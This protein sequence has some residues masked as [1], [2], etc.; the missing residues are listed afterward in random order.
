MITPKCRDG[1][2]AM[3][4]MPP[5]AWVPESKFNQLP[6]Y[7]TTIP[8]GKTIGKQWKAQNSK[9]MWFLCEYKSDPDPR[10]IN[11]KKLR[12]IIVKGQ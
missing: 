2:A 6:E 4:F 5:I 3:N 7:S 12:I 10:Y 1:F 9:G 11:I 8:T